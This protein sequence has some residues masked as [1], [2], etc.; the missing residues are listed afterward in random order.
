MTIEKMNQPQ[1]S[2]ADL[3]ARCLAGDTTAFGPLIDRSR[4]RL[5]RL[6]RLLLN[7]S[8]DFDDVWQETLLRAYLNL[9]QLHD[10][11]RFGAWVCSIAI[12]LARRRRHISFR[13]TFLRDILADETSNELAWRDEE[14]FSPESLVVKQDMVRRVRQAIADLPPA[15]REAV[16]LVYLN[17][18]SHQEAATQLGSSLGA[19]KVRVHRGRHRLRTVLQDEFELITSHPLKERKMIKVKIHDVM[20]V[21]P[22]DQSGRPKL[23]LGNILNLENRVLILKEEAGDRAIDIWMNACEI[24]QIISQL[25]QQETQRPMTYDLT[26]TL[27]DLGQVVVERV[28]VSRL[29]EHTF[30]GTMIVKTGSTVSEVDCRPSDAIT[31][32][33]RLDVPIFVASEIMD[34]ESFT[35]NPDGT[36][37]WAKYLD[38]KMRNA[39]TE[40]ERDDLSKERA[41]SWQSVLAIDLDQVAQT[42]L[43][44]GEQAWQWIRGLDDEM[45]RK[46]TDLENRQFIASRIKVLLGRSLI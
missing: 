11:A 7:N 29:H 2:D 22:Q 20:I 10:P 8:P 26:K 15:E 43:K 16:I 41:W 35:P 19:V 24:R 33:L 34:R 23:T 37:T 12:N 44:T 38:L 6:L 27:L 5:T 17:E 42:H 46:Q 13:Q 21:S 28:I 45:M 9:E 39:G 32:A 30:Y 14:R 3:V 18:L 40:Q 1:P 36:Y 25:E 4:T 31:L